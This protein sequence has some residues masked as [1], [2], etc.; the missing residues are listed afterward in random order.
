MTLR[1]CYFSVYGNNESR[2]NNIEL[3]E[4]AASF[5]EA[6]QSK[7]GQFIELSFQ[8]QGEP[9][10][11]HKHRALTKVSKGIYRT[12]VDFANL[13]SVK[14]A[15]AKGERG[16][17]Q[18]LSWGVWKVFPFIIGHKGN[19]YCRITTSPSHTPSVSYFVDGVEVSKEHYLSLL[20]PSKRKPSEPSEV[21]TI[22]AEN[23]IKVGGLDL[24]E[25]KEGV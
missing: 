22:K 4:K 13:S 23:I 1:T 24:T 8:S 14:E 16:E 20:P 2:M 5:L 15:I 6:V 17:V 10:A 19:D 25:V 18:P 9:S 12:G 7:K 21:F 11:E 3:H